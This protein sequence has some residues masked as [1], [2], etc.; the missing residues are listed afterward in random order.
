MATE[1]V[2]RSKA[3]E[4]SSVEKMPR[5]S[6]LM[7]DPETASSQPFRVPDSPPMP[8]YFMRALGYTRQV[9]DCDHLHSRFKTRWTCADCGTDL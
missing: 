7:L 9:Y 8:N 3:I 2:K 5:G 6:R 1:I 4:P